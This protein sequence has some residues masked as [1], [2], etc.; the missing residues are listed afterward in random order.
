VKYQ[1][2]KPNVVTLVFKESLFMIATIINMIEL[3]CSNG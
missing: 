2:Q 1:K 3:I